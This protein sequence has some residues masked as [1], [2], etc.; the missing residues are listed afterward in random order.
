MDHLFHS[1]FCI[2][3]G[4]RIQEG[5]FFPFGNEKQPEQKRKKS[6]ILTDEKQIMLDKVLCYVAASF[7]LIVYS[8]LCVKIALYLLGLVIMIL[9]GIL[10]VVVFIGLFILVVCIL[11]M[12]L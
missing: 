11:A 3:N 1:V 10:Q 5:L 4:N 8:A 7:C 12:F 2:L 6:T 9:S